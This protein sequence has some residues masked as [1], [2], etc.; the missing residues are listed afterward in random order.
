MAWPRQRTSGAAKAQAPINPTPLSYAGTR[1]LGAL[2]AR[3]SSL[4]ARCASTAGASSARASSL[5]LRQD[6]RIVDVLWLDSQA[7]ARPDHDDRIIAGAGAASSVTRFPM[8]CI[9]I[10]RY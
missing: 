10:R 5:D 4:P 7:K 3:L 8:R 2:P 9:P 1:R 6:L